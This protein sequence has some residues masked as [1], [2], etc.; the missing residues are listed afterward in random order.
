MKRKKFESWQ[1]KKLESETLEKG[2]KQKQQ[3][4]EEWRVNKSGILFHSK[5]S[6]KQKVA[7]VGET[8]KRQGEERKPFNSVNLHTF[9]LQTR[10]DS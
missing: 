6:K 10:Y 2:W 7:R 8:R 5:R 4:R 9:S 3:I 1:G